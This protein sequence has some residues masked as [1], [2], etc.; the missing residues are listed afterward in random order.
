MVKPTVLKGKKWM[1]LVVLLLISM[2]L[3]CRNTK[4]TEA[5]SGSTLYPEETEE[6]RYISEISKEDCL[7]CG[8]GRG[9]LLPLHWGKKILP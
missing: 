6:P 3:G 8:D 4:E 5:L 1:L 2:L 7:L 9:A